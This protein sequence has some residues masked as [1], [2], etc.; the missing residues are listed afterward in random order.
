MTARKADLFSSALMLSV[1]VLMAGALGAC[2]VSG[3]AKAAHAGS[4]KKTASASPYETTNQIPSDLFK[5][6]P[7][8]PGSKVVHVRKPKGG[9]REI[10][11]ELNGAPALDK[12]VSFY[13]DGL[14]KNNFIITSSLMLRVRNT[15][16]CDFHK[17]GRPGNIAL[18]PTGK[19]KSKMTIDLIYEIPSK[20]EQ[21]FL[22]PVEKF[23]V[24][25]PGRPG[26]VA[27]TAPNENEKVKRN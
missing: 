19:D 4:A 26:T 3:P 14:K 15:W 17:Q 7:I 27:Q 8:Y 12:L 11:F 25:G 18:Y 9:M 10:V 5:T 1:S 23:D 22:A 16:S 6:M 13:K 20:S 2:R 21:A 24:I